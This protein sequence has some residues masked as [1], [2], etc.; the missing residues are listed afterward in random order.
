MVK[1]IKD[2]LDGHNDV[3][4]KDGGINPHYEFIGENGVVT[5]IVILPN[6]IEFWYD[7]KDKI[8]HILVEIDLGDF[9]VFMDE[10]VDFIPLSTD[11]IINNKIWSVGGK[12]ITDENSNVWSWDAVIMEVDEAIDRIRYLD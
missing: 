3:N 2:Y 5:V 4:F 12:L 9:K 11:I 10:L 8:Q 6:H 7:K 1:Q